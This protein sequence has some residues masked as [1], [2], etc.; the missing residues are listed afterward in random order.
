MKARHTL[1]AVALLPTLATASGNHADDRP[2]AVGTPGDPANVDRTIDVTM[3]DQLRFVPD[4]IEVEAGQTIRFA[5]KNAGNQ[6]HEMVIDSHDELMEHAREM[7]Q[8]PD[9][10]HHEPNMV[11]L[12]GGENG[13]IV[14]HFTSPGEIEFACLIPGHLAAGMKGTIDVR[15]AH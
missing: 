6:P 3:N 2:A 7:R 8:H 12:K 15:P 5:V 14:W 1:L 11:H 13:A 10:I 4:H 9:M